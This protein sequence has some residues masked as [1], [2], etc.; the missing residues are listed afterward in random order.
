MIFFA[1][2]YVASIFCDD[3]VLSDAAVQAALPLSSSLD[4]DADERTFL[5]FLGLIISVL[6][7]ALA[8]GVG[9]YF[10]RATGR[11]APATMRS[12]S[13]HVDIVTTNQLLPSTAAPT[14]PVHRQLSAVAVQQAMIAQQQ[15]T[16]PH[17]PPSSATALDHF[18][19]KRTK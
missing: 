7:L 14:A 4:D 18:R 11:R 15:L 17:E 5:L 1:L 16:R 2:L 3:A 8:F 19:I 6:L 12:N 10:G 9:F 13:H